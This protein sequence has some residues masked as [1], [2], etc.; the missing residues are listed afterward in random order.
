MSDICKNWTQW[1]SE[2]RFSHMDEI[3][4]E[5]TFRWLFALR[6][7]VIS[8]AGIKN[9]DKIIDIGCGTG[10]LSFGVLEKFQ[11]NVELIFSDKFEDCLVECEKIL[12]ESNI[13]NRASFL[14]SD[15][16]DI[17]LPDNAV[18][19]AL[20]R[21]VLVHIVDKQKAINEIYRILKQGGT[22]SAF[23]PII[24]SNT[25]YHELCDPSSITD[26]EEFKKAED[27][28]MSDDC[29][30]LTNFDAQTIAQNL[31]AAG[32]S[33][34]N[35]NVE[36]TPSTYVAKK[37]AIDKWFDSAPSPDRPTTRQRFLKY[38]DEKKVNNYIEEV[39]LALDNKMITVT[40]KTMF[41]RATK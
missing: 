23:E 19:V 31:D 9:N 32:F 27:D 10:L 5:Q 39:K 38:F 8:N 35:I 25:R 13:K 30:P 40:S 28:F 16:L 4:K 17:K 14:Q 6:D 33:D 15:C 12:K 41:I 7:V 37:E 11:D 24:R 2:T 3:Q 29:D 22:Y 18:D 36:D 34:G 26:W 1:L 21:S 20:T